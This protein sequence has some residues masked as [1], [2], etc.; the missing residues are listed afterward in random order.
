MPIIIGDDQILVEVLPIPGS[1]PTGRL[2]DAKARIVD[3]AAQ[4][5]HVIGSVV[6]ASVRAVTG[7]A[8][9][10]HAPTSFEVEF[11]L[12]FSAE[13]NVI[14]AGATGEASLKI[15]LLYGPNLDGGGRD[16]DD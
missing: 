11:G 8:S 14:V 13:G 16:G 3:A 6:A 4:I 10:V 2:D 9:R 7:A 12:K 1:Q 5:D 15:K